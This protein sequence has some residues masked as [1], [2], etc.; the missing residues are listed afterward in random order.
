M[1]PLTT[2]KS[3]YQQL[4]K[5]F[6]AL[7][8]P[9]RI[10]LLDRLRNGSATVSELA[11]PFDMTMSGIT[12]HLNILEKVGLVSKKQD[13]QR[14]PTTLVFDPFKDIDLWLDKYRQI[15]KDR[16]DNLDKFMQEQGE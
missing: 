6:S 7:A 5:I 14:R 11:K 10:E 4:S 12:N 2:N 13:A 1:R 9:T 15:W 8:N 16:L 3:E